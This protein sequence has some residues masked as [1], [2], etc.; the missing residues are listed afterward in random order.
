MNGSASRPGLA[1]VVQ[2]RLR[3]ASRRQPRQT[4]DFRL[5]PEPSLRPPGKLS[6]P[7][8]LHVLVSCAPARAVADAATVLMRLSRPPV[9]AWYA[10]GHPAASA[11]GAEFLASSITAAKA[12]LSPGY[13]WRVST[14]RCRSRESNPILLPSAAP[15]WRGRATPPG[16][17]RSTSSVGPQGK[18]VPPRLLYDAETHPSPAAS[19][20]PYNF[21]SRDRAR[22]PTTNS[23]G[24]AHWLQALAC[25]LLVHAK[26]RSPLN[27]FELMRSSRRSSSARHARPAA[28]HTKRL[29]EADH[30][31]AITST[32]R[33]ARGH[34]PVGPQAASATT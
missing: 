24:G 29:A 9:T 11:R 3:A 25:L 34:E 14:S 17:S 21:G 27:R 15:C 23:S 30:L 5:L 7:A 28:E 12:A 4:R 31:P 18:C 16:A 32:T 33:A 20:H 2:E 6:D 22:R 26:A 1:G 8:A 19:R 10:R 13:S